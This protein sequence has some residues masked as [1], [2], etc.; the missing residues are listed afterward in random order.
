[1]NTTTNLHE[2]QPRLE[3]DLATSAPIENHTRFFHA[4]NP[5]DLMAAM[6]AIKKYVDVSGRKAIVC[7][8]TTQEAA[9][10][11]GATHPTVDSRGV[12]VCCNEP[13][14]QMLK[15]L[16]ESQYYVHSF[17]KYEGQKIDIDLNVIRHKTNV[18]L[19]N[20]SIQGWIPLAYPD[21]SFDISQPW[22]KLEGEC[23][24]HIKKQVAGKVILNFT[25]RYRNVM[26][27]YFFLKN[28]APDLVFAGTEKEHWLFA[29]KWQLN[30]P[31]LEVNDFLELAHGIR[32]ARFILANQSFAVNI[33]YSM[34][35][36]RIVEICA[37]A[38][39]VPHMVGEHCYGFL[40]QVGVEYYF[41]K[42]YN[43]TK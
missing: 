2:L 3:K 32:E 35:T 4:V 26:I 23:P 40:Y 41:R 39:N 30:I 14:W 42:L 9:Y 43:L 25:E 15:P 29:N 6:G 22:I 31:R 33:A 8:S 12:N 16:I 10:Y 38:Q 11:Q 27:D 13:M 37:Y 18:N 7:Q 20:G 28:Y 24:E 19:P 1:M 21:L 17:E 36:P 34:G 5:G